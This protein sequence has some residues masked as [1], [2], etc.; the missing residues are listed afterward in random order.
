MNEGES[1]MAKIY[2]T[3]SFWQWNSACP[4]TDE[5]IL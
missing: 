3:N 2:I 4:D 1:I 5:N